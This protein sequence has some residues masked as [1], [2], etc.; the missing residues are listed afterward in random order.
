M[1]H[2]YGRQPQLPARRTLKQ[3]APVKAPPPAPTPAAQ[4]QPKVQNSKLPSPKFYFHARESGKENMP[5][6]G[7]LFPVAIPLAEPSRDPSK[8]MP[9]YYSEQQGY[10]CTDKPSKSFLSGDSRLV[11]EIF[12]ISAVV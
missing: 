6:T 1:R 3:N 9:I 11:K 4:T 8:R 7:D 2:I 12:Y 10:H 5:V